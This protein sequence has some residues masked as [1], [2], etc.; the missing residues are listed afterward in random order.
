MSWMCQVVVKETQGPCSSE[1]NAKLSKQ[2]SV[3]TRGSETPLNAWD[4]V[5]KTEHGF[6]VLRDGV[7][8]AAKLSV[9][10][11]RPERACGS[12]KRV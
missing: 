11:A 1:S 3:N 5:K 10:K 6:G 8:N 12:V 2:L 4:G 9:V 7:D